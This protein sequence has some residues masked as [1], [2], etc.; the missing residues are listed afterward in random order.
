MSEETKIGN[1]EHSSNRG[2]ARF[3]AAVGLANFGDGIAVVAWAWTASLLTRDPL[4]IAILPATLRVP[5][6]LFA[7]I[8]G[9][10]ADRADRRKLIVLCDV[11]RAIAYGAAAVL[12]FSNLPLAE[13]AVEGVGNTSLY[14]SLLALGFVIGSAEVT[15]DNAAQTML[16]A[17]VAADRLERANGWLGSV[18]TVGNEMAGPA[19]GA[20]LLAL[21]LPAPFI[22][23]AFAFL[24]AALLTGS[25]TGNFKAGPHLVEPPRLR[26]EL[27]EGFR[28]VTGEPLLRV[29]VIVT[30]FWNFFA[31][32][33]L[34][35]L[36]LHVQENLTAGSTTYGL[37]LAVGAL[38]GVFGGVIVSPLLKIMSKGAMAQWTA[39]ASTPVFLLIA[40]APGP[41]TVAI[42]LFI[43][44]LT[45][46][47]W[48]TLSISYRQR[49]VPDEIRGR[50]N[51]VYRLFA[52][53]TMPLGC[54][55]RARW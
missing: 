20:F 26:E 29:L 11:I 24:L 42:A 9:I 39:L 48:N 23:V 3:G 40:A 46:I 41:I 22:V 36:V 15:R 4:W 30:G 31:Q 49:V 28:F 53:G 47:M 25:L 45:G 54:S 13:P 1:S 35:A 12:I 16:P 18:E 51:S 10:L 32:M 33:V 7:L 2:F 38:G 8:S 44:Y 55:H 14:F 21:F 6:V 52:W 37:I 5:W 43:F 34:I 19:L 50:V 17:I 27:M